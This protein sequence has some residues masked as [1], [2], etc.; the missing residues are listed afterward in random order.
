VLAVGFLALVVAACSREGAPSA[1]TESPRS[2]TEI[3]AAE[4][5]GSGPRGDKSLVRRDVS[6]CPPVEPTWSRSDFPRRFFPRTLVGLWVP[7]EQSDCVYLL[8]PRSNVLTPIWRSKPR[9]RLR[10]VLWA[11]DGKSFA[12]ALNDAAHSTW[13]YLVRR[14]G[15]LLRRLSAR[16][17]AFLRNGRLLVTRQ[18]GIYLASGIRLE[19]LATRAEL[20][21][22]AGFPSASALSFRGGGYGQNQ[23]ALLWA[24]TKIQRSI[25]LVVSASGA[26]LRASPTFGAESER[27]YSLGGWIWSPDGRRL[28]AM[29]DAPTPPGFDQGHDHCLDVWDKR[30]GYHR[31]SC[32]TDY[33]PRF[34]FHFDRLAWSADGNAALLNNGTVVRPD[35]TIL[36]RGRGRDAW[37]AFALEW[38]R[39][40]K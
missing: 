16:S 1:E 39:T 30:R 22:T 8:P 28:F 15:T 10:G 6:A 3:G 9:E 25:L 27:G 36:G 4:T 12:L 35:G 14:D 32:T 17:A 11:P 40:P 2:S 20:R 37:G 18:D 33:P 19:Q 24:N 13:V 23:V 21:R 38:A 26:I 7:D 5:G 34:R 31:L 29:P